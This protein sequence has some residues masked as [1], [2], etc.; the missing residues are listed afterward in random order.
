[1]H[2]SRAKNTAYHSIH[3][4]QSKQSLVPACSEPAGK[5]SH[6]KNTISTH[7]SLSMR[8][9]APAHVAHTTCAP[10][11][12][13]WHASLLRASAWP[14]LRLASASK[15]SE[16]SNPTATLLLLL[17][18]DLDAALLLRVDLLLGVMALLLLLLPQASREPSAACLAR[19]NRA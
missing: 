5:G 3:R 8:S 18:A 1:M 10:L 2:N 6:K 4:S 13:C 14:H 16:S 17:P 19:S 11:S 12:T 7:R 9:P 15:L